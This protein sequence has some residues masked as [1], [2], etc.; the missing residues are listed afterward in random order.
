MTRPDYCECY[1]CKMLVEREEVK[2]TQSWLVVAHNGPNEIIV[3]LCKKCWNKRKEVKK[4]GMQMQSVEAKQ[5][6]ANANHTVCKK[7]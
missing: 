7:P 5:P 1:D 6:K 4:N 2:D 3:P